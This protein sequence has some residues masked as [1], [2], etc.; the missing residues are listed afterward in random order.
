MI[1]ELRQYKEKKVKVGNIEINFAEAGKGVPLLFIHGWTNNWWGWIPVALR[2]KKYFRVIMIDLPGYG[3]SGRLKSYSLKIEAEY[4]RLFLEALK[5][6]KAIMIGHSMGTYV[7][8]K[9]VS[10]FPEKI[11]KVILIGAV[12]RGENKKIR[13]SITNKFFETVQGHKKNRIIGKKCG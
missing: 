4:I 6:D 2:L 11:N 8:S 10:L 1:A 13:L 12:F 9:F 7:V 5:I 3:D